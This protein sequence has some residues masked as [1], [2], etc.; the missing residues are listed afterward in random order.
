M[1][2]DEDPRK[3]NECNDQEKENYV[4]NTKNVN[5]ISSTVNAASKNENNELPFDLNMPTLEDVS[6]FNFLSDDEDDGALADMNNLVTIIQIE[7]EVCVCQPTGFEDPDFPD[8]VYKVEKALYGLHQAPRSCY[9]TLSTYL[10]ENGFQ[11][12]KNDKTIFINGIKVIF[13]LS[14]FMWLISSLVQLRRSY[15]MH[16]KS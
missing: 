5:T 11:R 3:E 12:G 13:C 8:R 7:E 1:K 2:V 16:L 4:N 9:E 6:T 10:L 15:A 14:K